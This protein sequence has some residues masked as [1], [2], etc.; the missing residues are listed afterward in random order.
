MT[1]HRYVQSGVWRLRIA[2]VDARHADGA[3]RIGSIPIAPLSS[4]WTRLWRLRFPDNRF[5]GI[6]SSGSIEH[7][8]GLM[9]VAHSAYEMGRVLKPGGILS[10]S[11]VMAIAG[12][13]GRLGGV[14]GACLLF[15]RDHLLRYI[16]EASGLELPRP[17][18]DHRR[19]A[20]DARGA[21]FAGTGA[22]GGDWRSPLAQGLK[23]S[24]EDY[25]DGA[26]PC[27]ALDWE[28]F[29]VRLRAPRPAQTAER[30]GAPRMPGSARRRAVEAQVSARTIAA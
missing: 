17:L 14:P 7:F 25:K 16:V 23:G 18:V 1:V 4:T 28:G 22:D 11:T 10:L 13:P 20:R 19:H 9:D 8:G 21:P 30:D 2:L 6:F 26:F 12:P 5:D 15:Q 24:Q 27:I 3:R 29:H